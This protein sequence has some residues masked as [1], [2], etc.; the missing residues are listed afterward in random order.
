MGRKPRLEYEGAIY[1]VIQRGNNREYIFEKEEDKESLIKDIF[2]K[3]MDLNFKLIGYVIMDNHFHILLQVGEK[4]LQSIMHRINSKYSKYYNRKCGRSGHVYGERYK[5]IL[6]QNE[7]YLLVLL[8]Y[9]HQNPI[10]AGICSK[11]EEYRWSSD[12]YYRTE[13][14]A[15][16]D[17]DIIFGTLSGDREIALK[18]YKEFMKEIDENNYNEGQRIGGEAFDLIAVP[19]VQVKERKRLDEILM[20]TGVSMEEYQ[21]IKIGSRRRSLTSYKIS[22]AKKAQ[23]L[24][25]TLKEIGS[26]IKL[27]DAAIFKLIN[28]QV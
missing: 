15:G 1:H 4:P 10:R 25:Y 22:Y 14:D 27:S 2:S 19:R 8:R 3:K 16:I 11:V 26:N 17:I 28:N 13:K 7:S 21:Q 18:Q 24:N 12:S 6:V 23:E 20:E 9:M 5:A